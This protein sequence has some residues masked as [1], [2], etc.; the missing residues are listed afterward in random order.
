LSHFGDLVRAL[1]KERCWTLEAVARKIGTQKGYISGIETGK[2]APP[3]VKVIK[4]YAKALGQ[5]PKHL[6]RI[7][8]VDKAPKLIRDDAERFLEWCQAGVPADAPKPG[9]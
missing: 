3:S 2:V 4:K 5:D 7:A 9:A 6:V 8:W 1:R